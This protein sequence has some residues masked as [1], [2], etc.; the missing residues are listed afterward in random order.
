MTIEEKIK[1][2]REKI[3]QRNFQFNRE[4]EVIL[5]FSHDLRELIV[6]SL[7][8][9]SY[10]ITGMDVNDIAEYDTSF[11][12]HEEEL[13]YWPNL[14]KCWIHSN[15]A[16]YK[17]D[18]NNIV[19]HVNGGP[20]LKRK[21]T[22]IRN[23]ALLDPNILIDYIEADEDLIRFL[24]VNKCYKRIESV[25]D[26]IEIT[27]ELYQEIIKLWPDDIPY[28]SFINRYI[29]NRFPLEEKSLNAVLEEFVNARY[30]DI[31]EE[32]YT[33][34]KN[35]AIQR[36]KQVRTLSELENSQYL[37]SF[38]YQLNEE[39]KQEVEKVLH[40]KGY[41]IYFLNRYPEKTTEILEEQI[42][43]GKIKTNDFS[44]AS[45]ID[46]SNKTICEYIIEN[47]LVQVALQRGEK[48]T[49]EQVNRVVANIR[50]HKPSYY[51]RNRDG[52]IF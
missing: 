12:T 26:N 11:L 35:L 21:L 48:L 10:E 38:I 24:L 23:N 13:K 3:S 5:D 7:V 1:N 46:M 33:Y 43:T 45:K 4:E 20:E 40:D 22:E 49:P 41:T 29:D 39:E 18:I 34:L 8:E 25:K 44:Y 51:I 30:Q 32:R 52:R 37:S 9:N 15:G 27:D 14:Y 28:P 19:D 16:I 47:G 6:R 42:L 36:V 50:A 17:D 31:P 2:L